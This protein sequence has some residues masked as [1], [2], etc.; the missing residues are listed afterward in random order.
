M[1][2]QAI[3]DYDDDSGEWMDEARAMQ[4]RRRAVRI[5]AAIVCMCACWAAAWLF[6]DWM[7]TA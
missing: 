5:I 7:A 1:S 6:A 4:R 3:R 2:K